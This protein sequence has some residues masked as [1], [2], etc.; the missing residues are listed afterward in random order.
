MVMK[1]GAFTVLQ[2]IMWLAVIGLL[3]VA[4]YYGGGTDIWKSANPAPV[5]NGV[6][7]SDWQMYQSEVYDFE[8]RYPPEWRHDAIEDS[9]YIV[10]RAAGNPNESVVLTVDAACIS[11]AGFGSHAVEVGENRIEAG[12]RFLTGNVTSREL[13][14]FLYAAVG[15]RREAEG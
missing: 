15:F 6:N 2:T 1:T 10:F 13:A 5:I 12:G 3:A 7:V 8:F 4:L 11:A 9:P 14:S